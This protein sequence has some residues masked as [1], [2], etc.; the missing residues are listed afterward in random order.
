MLAETDHIIRIN[1]SSIQ[2][3]LQIRRSTVRIDGEDMDG[4]L[5]RGYGH[6]PAVVG[7]FN[8]FHDS[9]GASTPEIIDMQW[10]I[11]T[12]RRADGR[13]PQ[14]INPGHLTIFSGR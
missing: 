4:S 2:M 14:A 1:Y 9:R 10:G 13:R 5:A 8:A 7:P 12:G 3:T 6:P 11:I